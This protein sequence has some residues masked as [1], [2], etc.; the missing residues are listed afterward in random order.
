MRLTKL[1]RYAKKSLD[2]RFKHILVEVQSVK[3]FEDGGN[4]ELQSG[5]GSAQ[6]ISVPYSNN[7]VP[8]A[9]IIQIGS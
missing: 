2:Q 9:N 1:Y 8:S 7:Y 6:S 3:S 4:I 5:G